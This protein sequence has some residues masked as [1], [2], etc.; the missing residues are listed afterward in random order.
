MSPVTPD[1]ER[2]R[3]RMGRLLRAAPGRGRARVPRHRAGDA[4]RPR[5]RV[6]VPRSVRHEGA[7]REARV[8]RRRAS[9]ALDAADPDA[10]ELR[11]QPR[12]HVSRRADRRREH[13]P[14]RRQ[15][16]HGEV[17]VVPRRSPGRPEQRR[18]RGRVGRQ[19]RGLARPRGMP[20]E[21]DPYAARR[22][23]GHGPPVLRRLGHRGADADA[24]RA[25]RRLERAPD[26]SP[27]TRSSPG[28][29]RPS[30]G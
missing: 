5:H 8:R 14:D 12:L 27:P 9:A 22:D 4:A 29:T 20:E 2:L 17:G 11:R 24:H 15:P 3:G 23:A 19:L 7:A 6:P 10:Q 30:V 26:R 16:R 1:D 18:P 13:V 25:R 28:S 21:L